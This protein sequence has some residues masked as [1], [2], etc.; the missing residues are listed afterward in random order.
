MFICKKQPDPKEP[1]RIRLISPA[2]WGA[3]S[4]IQ[5]RIRKNKDENLAEGKSS[6]RFTFSIRLSDR[7][8]FSACAS[9][10][11]WERRGGFLPRL[12]PGRFG[13]PKQVQIDC[14]TRVRLLMMKEA[15]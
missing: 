12:R 4:K 9:D 8:V 13:Q 3:V 7:V 6:V 1:K 11:T 14:G 2:R 5:V 15:A 10:R